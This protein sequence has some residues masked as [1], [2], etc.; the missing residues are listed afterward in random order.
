[1][2]C[3][4]PGCEGL[5]KGSELC[6]PASSWDSVEWDAP[7]VVMEVEPRRTWMCGDGARWLRGEAG[8]GARFTPMG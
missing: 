7:G 4:V 2:R 1:M 3:C 8:A 5:Q 6:H